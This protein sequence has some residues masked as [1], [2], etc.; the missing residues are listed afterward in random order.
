M[1]LK[2]SPKRII[3]IDYHFNWLLLI[4]LA[5]LC[6]LTGYS[7]LIEHVSGVQLIFY[8]LLTLLILASS[9]QIITWRR[10]FHFKID[11]FA[12]TLTI[13]LGWRGTRE[14]PLANLHSVN[15]T[16][17]RMKFRT[18]YQL[19]LSTDP[20]TWSDY[21]HQSVS[22]RAK[23]EANYIEMFIIV[24]FTHQTKNERIKLVR[25]LNRNQVPIGP[26]VP[27]VLGRYPGTPK[28][29]RRLV[30]HWLRL[31]QLLDYFLR[32]LVLVVIVFTSLSAL[33]GRFF[34]IY[35]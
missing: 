19:Q 26:V 35:W 27:A 1:I 12:E 24:T 5:G 14:L 25:T 21:H 18:F 28:P 16:G 4:L 22:T 17:F 7:A 20:K 10:P 34:G 23:N 13:D 8:V 9:H 2:R 33:Y 11:P 3:T 30:I 29:S 32:R 15:L 6:A 31:Q